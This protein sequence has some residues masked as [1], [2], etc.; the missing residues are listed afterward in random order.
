MTSN[1]LRPS[2]CRL[3]LQILKLLEGLPGG[4][5][6]T[7]VGDEYVGATVSNSTSIGCPG[8]PGPLPRAFSYTWV[9][10]PIPNIQKL[11]MTTIPCPQDTPTGKPYPK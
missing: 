3:I 9:P 10:G 6:L 5:S 8:I 11:N 2:F 4:S 1:K 7:G